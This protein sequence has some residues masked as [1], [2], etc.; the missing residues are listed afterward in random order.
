MAIRQVPKCFDTSGARF[1]LVKPNSKIPLDLGWNKIGGTN[2]TFDEINELLKQDEYKDFNVGKVLGAGE[3]D[4]EFDTKEAQDKYQPLLGE[5]LQ[6]KS[7]IK[8]GF[9]NIFISDIKLTTAIND[10]DGK[11]A[12]DILAGKMGAEGKYVY[13]QALIPPSFI[14]TDSQGN[15]V[16]R[17]YEITKDIPP[18]YISEEEVNEI[19]GLSKHEEVM[20]VEHTMKDIGPIRDEIR[21][22]VSISSQLDKY[23]IPIKNRTRYNTICPLPHKD[24]NGKDLISMSGANFHVDEEKHNWYC[25]NDVCKKGGDVLT[26]RSLKEEKTIEEVAEEFAKELGLEYDARQEDDK[27]WIKHP[28]PGRLHSE[29]IKEVAEVL[30]DKNK[31]FLRPESQDIVELTRL[32][33]HE[34]DTKT[35]EGFQIVKPNRFITLIENYITPFIT[36]KNPENGNFIE[37]EKSISAEL[38]NTVLSSEELKNELKP[39]RRLFTVPIPVMYKGELTFPKKGYDD[40]FD[41]WLPQDAPDLTNPNM[42]IQEATAI[43]KG[44]YKEFCFKDKQD[45]HNAIAALLTPY[46]KGLYPQFNTRAPIFC[47]LANRERSG[48][49]YCAGITGIVYENTSLE[50]PPISTGESSFAD[51][52]NELRKKILSA[53]MSGR[54]RL[55][56]ANNKGFINN[57]TLESVATAKS[58]SDRQLGKSENLVFDNM[59]DFSL[60]GNVGITYTPDLANRMV[61]INLFLDIEDANSRRFSNPNLHEYVSKRR[62]EILSALFALVRNWIDKGSV[63]GSKPFTSFPEWARVCGGILEAAGFNSPCVKNDELA[64]E[65][66]DPET[67]EMKELFE[68]CYAN[69]KDVWITKN[70]I[71]ELVRQNDEI[72][73]SIDFNSKAGLT[74]FGIKI[75]KFIGRIQSGI[76]LKVDDV[77]EKGFRQKFMFSKQLQT[78][79]SN[80]FDN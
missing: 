44:V 52:S 75:K 40:R 72:F 29:M 77:K 68:I 80:V 37:K 31:I 3:V 35:Y 17:S 33:E 67:A 39:I 50:E 20:V 51:S 26:L 73:T 48:K 38:A 7:A 28:G 47:Y 9:H 60:S 30:K 2:Y 65:E 64:G 5:T 62:G 41:S 45:Y 23:K 57:S 1:I 36:V 14:K 66:S 54:Q 61:F 4:I 10:S 27:V 78:T 15:E 11:R 71:I 42:G 74:K 70:T 43:L 8:E 13:S 76:L 19:F 63:A 6:F 49:D 56:F 21:K 22:R 69:H 16:N 58:W 59:I 53:F 18:K 32:K 55:H 46:L 34:L 24:K 12:V 25:H 79:M